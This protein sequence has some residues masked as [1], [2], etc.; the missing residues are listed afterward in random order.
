MIGEMPTRIRKIIQTVMISA[1]LGNNTR[2]HSTAQNNLNRFEQYSTIV[3]RYEKIVIPFKKNC[4]RQK[5]GAESNII[6]L[7]SYH[8]CSAKYIMWYYLHYQ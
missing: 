1:R 3:L 8:Y 7:L 2:Q 6:T 4:L 5:M